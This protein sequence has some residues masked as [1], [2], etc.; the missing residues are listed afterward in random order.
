[1]DMLV[2]NYNSAIQKRVFAYFKE[3]VVIFQIVNL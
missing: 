2:K 3:L 1:M